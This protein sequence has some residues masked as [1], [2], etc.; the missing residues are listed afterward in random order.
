MANQ[1]S[2]GTE[3]MDR[4]GGTRGTL[5]NTSVMLQLVDDIE[6]LHRLRDNYYNVTTNSNDTRNKNNLQQLVFNKLVNSSNKSG[7]YGRSKGVI[8]G[9]SGLVEGREGIRERR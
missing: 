4:L 2:E 7:V 5:E 8:E 1:Y 6:K 3:F 9:K